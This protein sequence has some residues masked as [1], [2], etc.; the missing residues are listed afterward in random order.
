MKYIYLNL[1][2]FDITPEYGGVNRLAPPEKWAEEI[3]RQTDEALREFKG[4]A[5][6][7]DFFPEAHILS[8]R[9]A[10][11]PDSVLELGCQGVHWKD[12]EPDGNFG[13]FTTSMPASS[14]AGIGCGHC[15][16]GHCEERGKTAELI[17]LCSGNNQGDVISKLMNQEI[18]AAQKRD[19]EVLY[20]VG[21]AEGETETWREVI[22]RQVELGL[23]DADLAKAAVA[24]EP[25]WS[26]G[27]GKTPAGR[28]HIEKVASLIKDLT[29][30]IPVVYGGGL[31]QANAEMLA[32]IDVI[33]GGLIALTRFEGQIGFYPDEYIEIIKLYLGA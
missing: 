13:A 14:A 9:S 21:E 24:Y 29:G 4:R 5:R 7:I 17:R 16:I 19:L 28:E 33:D 25:L 15:I 18:L 11:G 6:F 2:R 22:K 1:K 30:G 27:P 8:A 12:S 10:L 26:I 32:S 3:V 23:Q 20:C 31:K